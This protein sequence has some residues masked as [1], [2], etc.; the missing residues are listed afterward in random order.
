M[1][2]G[3]SRGEDK[4]EEL[5]KK[6]NQRPINTSIPKLRVKYKWMK[7]QWC[8][9]TDIIKVGS[10]KSPVTEPRMVQNSGSN[11]FRDPH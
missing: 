9:I 7:D 2:A 3:Y 4:E 10:G 5:P 1:L 8:K 11:L 6:G